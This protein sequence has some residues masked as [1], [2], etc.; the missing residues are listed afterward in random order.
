MRDAEA[1][2]E[3]AGAAA[4]AKQAAAENLVTVS[5]NIGILNH[6]WCL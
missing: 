5:R 6:R 2:A 1:A 4:A 3:A